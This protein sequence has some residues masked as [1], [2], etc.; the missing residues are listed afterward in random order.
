MAKVLT[1]TE[2]T[3]KKLKKSLAIWGLIFS[4]AMIG[5]MFL[6]VAKMGRLS[7]G[8]YYELLF[9][10]I[11]GKVESVKYILAYVV[12]SAIAMLLTVYEL[13]QA[14][15]ALV[16]CFIRGKEATIKKNS[17]LDYVLALG[18]GILTIVVIFVLIRYISIGYAFE[19]NTP[20]AI[21]GVWVVASLKKMN[22]HNKIINQIGGTSA[23]PKQKKR[24][25][26]STAIFTLVGIIVAVGGGWT[27]FE[28]GGGV[29]AQELDKALADK[30]IVVGEPRSRD[31]KVVLDE[32]FNTPVDFN[33]MTEAGMYY[34]CYG[35][36]YKYYLT[37]LE[38]MKEYRASAKQPTGSNQE[39]WEKY[40]DEMEQLDK[41]IAYLSEF[42]SKIHFPYE[43]IQFGQVVVDPDT[44]D[45]S[46]KYQK[47]ALSYIYDAEPENEVKWG[48]KK[49]GPMGL[50]YQEKI[51]LSNYTF[52]V[53]TDFSTDN[54]T[55]WEQKYAVCKAE[56]IATV[57]YSDG[58]IRIS[59]IKEV[60]N[61]AELSTAE[62]GI[63]TLRWADE[64]GEYE[65]R[66]NIVQPAPANDS[67]VGE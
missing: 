12:I 35:I 49:S 21:A 50:M 13:G 47:R 39:K 9:Q 4:A 40:F 3:N 53:G 37:K 1:I 51:E 44:T 29:R 52:E 42:A 18:F 58:S 22:I 62:Q 2:Y 14:I 60:L 55:E 34:E 57:H 65:A 67:P 11:G 41:D 23:D 38:E 10:A 28:L 64:W 27:F 19:C 20:F 66:I 48:K 43:R 33:D 63:H 17:F 24:I 46:L 15:A 7:I 32:K 61:A 54:V 56:I 26:I 6:P 59:L 25:L 30:T 16:A 31:V 36:H 5:L 8:N 45:M